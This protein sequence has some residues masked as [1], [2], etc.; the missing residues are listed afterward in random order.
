MREDVEGVLG[1]SLRVLVEGM[2][3]LCL[4]FVVSTFGLV[5]RGFSWLVVL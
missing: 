1:V 5:V 4:R 2:V 3:G